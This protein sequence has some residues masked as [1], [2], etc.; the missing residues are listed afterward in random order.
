MLSHT[1]KLHFVTTRAMESV[2]ERLVF[3]LLTAL[4]SGIGVGL[5]HPRL[6]LV[7]TGIIFFAGLALISASAIY[8]YASEWEWRK[9][10]VVRRAH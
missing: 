10:M 4:L 8:R 2:T 1:N 5:L 9:V 6:T 3:L 7:T